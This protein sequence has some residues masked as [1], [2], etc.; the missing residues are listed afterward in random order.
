MPKRLFIGGLNYRTTEENL[1]A[2]IEAVAPLA[3]RENTSPEGETLSTPDIRIIWDRELNRSKGFG[4][5]EMEDEDGANK[6]INELNNQEFEGRSL[7]ISIAEDR[8]RREGGFTPGGRPSFGGGNN[9][10]GNDQM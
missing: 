7:K 6:V 8:P 1:A 2:Y 9:F 3:K 4:F 5:A 10:R